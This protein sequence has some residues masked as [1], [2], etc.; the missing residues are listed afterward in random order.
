MG[1]KQFIILDIIITLTL[2]QTNKKH[3]ISK[4]SKIRPDSFYDWQF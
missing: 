2:H 3:G 4:Y 1:Y